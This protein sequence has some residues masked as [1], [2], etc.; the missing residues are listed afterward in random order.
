MHYYSGSRK[1]TQSLLVGPVQ[2]GDGWLSVKI[3]MENDTW[4]T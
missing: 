3:V 2:E 1:L 4:N